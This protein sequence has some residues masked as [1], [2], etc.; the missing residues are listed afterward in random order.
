MQRRNLTSRSVSVGPSCHVCWKSHSWP[1]FQSAGT[2][3]SR[4]DH[5][6]WG[7]P[8]SL[9]FILTWILGTVRLYWKGNPDIE[10]VTENNLQS[11]AVAGQGEQKALEWGS[12][13]DQRKCEFWEAK[14]FYR[15]KNGIR[16]LGEGEPRAGSCFFWVRVKINHIQTK[17]LEDPTTISSN[18]T[19]LRGKTRWARSNHMLACS[20][21]KNISCK[22]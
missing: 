5:R 17:I 19:E 20:R 6:L 9:T 21:I 1:E 10:P 3:V 2:R 4:S 11:S 15:D 14:A 13:P 7:V 12:Y 22:N 18:A 16:L 8:D